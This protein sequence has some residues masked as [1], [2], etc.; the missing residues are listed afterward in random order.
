MTRDGQQQSGGKQTLT[1]IET[2]IE[3]TPTQTE[4]AAQ[5][6]SSNVRQYGQQ[7]SG[8]RK[9]VRAVEGQAHIWIFAKPD[10]KLLQPKTTSKRKK[11]RVTVWRSTTSG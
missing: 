7:Q 10:A 9:Q 1:Q 5:A 3:Q 4:Q 6:T 11:T 2:Q 8:A